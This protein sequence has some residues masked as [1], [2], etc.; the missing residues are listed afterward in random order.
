MKSDL[1][2]MDRYTQ[3]TTNA[4]HELADAVNLIEKAGLLTA[5]YD[6]GYWL[7]QV[8]AANYDHPVDEITRL[9]KKMRELEAWM[10]KERHEYLKKGAWLTNRLKDQARGPQP[11]C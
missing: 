2:N 5:V 6:Y 1:L 10:L 7:K 8:K 3:P 9:L 4:P 11:R